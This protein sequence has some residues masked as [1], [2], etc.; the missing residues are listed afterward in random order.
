MWLSPVRAPALGAGGREFESRHPDTTVLTFMYIDILTKIE[1]NIVSYLERRGIITHNIKLQKTI[2]DFEG[3]VTL[4]LFHLQKKI[5]GEKQGKIDL[6]QLGEDIGEYLKQ[7]GCIQSFSVVGGTFLNMKL[8]DRD[9]VKALEYIY[10]DEHFFMFDK[11]NKNIAVEYCSPNT[12]KPLHLGHL[13]NIFI[14]SSIV[15]I[16]KEVGYDVRTL[17]LVN[18]RGIHICK[19]MLAYLKYGGGKTP[20]STKI[21]GDHFVGDF[22]VLFEKMLQSQ[23]KELG[24]EDNA[25][26]PLMREAKELLKK[27]EDG[28]EEVMS[29]WK[30][31]N[32]WVLEGF[33][34]TYKKLGVSFDET[35]FESQTYLLGKEIVNEGLEKNIFYKKENGSI[36]VNLELYGL[37]NKLLLR[38]DGTSVYITQDLGT[39]DMRYNK[40]PFEKI[41]Y[42]VGDEQEYHFKV[43]KSILI[44]LD[45][46]YAEGL[47]HLAYGMI[48]LPSGKM[49][50]R[51][52]TVVDADDI[53]AEMIDK[54]LNK[55]EDT[56]KYEDNNEQEKRDIAEAIGLGAL[57]FFLLKVDPKR[58]LTFDPNKSIDFN[59]DTGPF[60]LYSNVRILSI[61]KKLKG[62]VMSEGISA[63]TSLE[64]V[65]K[66]L[67]LMI[68]DYKNKLEL[69]AN[70]LNPSVLASYALSLSKTFNKMYDT[71]PI[72][73]E[74]D[75]DKKQ[76]RIMMIKLLSRILT[77]IFFIFGIRSINKM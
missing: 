42:V 65:E 27:W 6:I 24:V 9:I 8:Y 37:D 57:R 62:E 18:D 12:N 45:K 2:D 4:V 58:R 48:D 76:L 3:D 56:G 74:Q 41:I 52:G 73:K 51:E 15:N 5:D 71:L 54:A 31:M 39:I 17:I 75:N 11:K 20:D 63:V 7:Q 35:D 49:K 22:Y 40:K 13:R 55:I 70:T 77:K 34:E 68:Y 30:K 14:G 47:Y 64:K 25:D 26:T 28:E 60:V 44:L 46:P 29:L 16:L 61:L 72:L 50:S 19:S 69:S 23:K 59:G 33:E 66:D 43:L 38:G 10:N 1:K 53:I 21:K 36:W 32:M 67:I